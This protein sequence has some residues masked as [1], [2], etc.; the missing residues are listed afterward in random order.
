MILEE[1]KAKLEEIDTNVFY[2]M[3]DDSMRETL[4]NYIVFS[5]SKLSASTNKTA[6]SDY[7]SV[8]IIRENWLP[9]GLDIQVIDK[10]LEIDGMRLAG[11]DGTY[12]YILK[13]KT[14]IVVEMLSLEFVKVRKKV[15][16]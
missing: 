7:Y 15:I 1:I 2:G 14:N 13:P 3:V 6:Y 11:S 12:H 9:E 8:H 5:R 4:W 10:M 16:T